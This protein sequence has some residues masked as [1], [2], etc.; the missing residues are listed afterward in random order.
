MPRTCSAAIQTGWLCCV[1]MMS[2]IASYQASLLRLTV[3]VKR[4]L[5]YFFILLAWA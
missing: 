3:A 2:L 4:W 5:Q 1:R